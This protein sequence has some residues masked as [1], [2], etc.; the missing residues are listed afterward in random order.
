MMRE[1]SR[2]EMLNI[3][4]GQVRELLMAAGCGHP[5]VDTLS[6]AERHLKLSLEEIKPPRGSGN[7]KFD[8]HREGNEEKSNWFVALAIAEHLRPQLLKRLD[9]TPAELRTMTGE[10]L[11]NLFATRLLVPSMWF[12]TD[13]PAL[14]YD[15]PDLK[16]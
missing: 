16:G 4:D 9:V 11:T 2:D 12:A 13:A 10:S 3:L 8:L 7:R 1:W 6:L 5:P 14:D 15:L